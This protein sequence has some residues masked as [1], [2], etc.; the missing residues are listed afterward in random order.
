MKARISF[1]Y[2]QT[3]LDTLKDV[4]KLK[5][6]K[7]LETVMKALIAAELKDEDLEGFNF[8]FELVPEKEDE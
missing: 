4:F 8:Q 3:I 6:Y 5:E 7:D 1:E 2:P